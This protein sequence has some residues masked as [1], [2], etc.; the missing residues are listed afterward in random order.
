MHV[1]KTF[2]KHVHI[3]ETGR[4]KVENRVI[5]HFSPVDFGIN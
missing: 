4:K 2:H 3:I 5:S 1:W